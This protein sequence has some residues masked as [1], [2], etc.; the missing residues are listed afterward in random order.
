[1]RQVTVNEKE[2]NLK[3]QEERRNSPVLAS[4]PADKTYEDKQLRECVEKY[5]RTFDLVAIPVQVLREYNK[6]K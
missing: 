3:E 5:L 4:L 6:G 1:M 2:L